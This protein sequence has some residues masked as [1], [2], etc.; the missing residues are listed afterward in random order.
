MNIYEKV[1]AIMADTPFI[2]GY[3]SRAPQPSLGG[4]LTAYY[5][6]HLDFA[7]ANSYIAEYTRHLKYHLLDKLSTPNTPSSLKPVEFPLSEEQLLHLSDAFEKDRLQGIAFCNALRQ[8][9]NY[10]DVSDEEILSS[11]GI[12]Y[13]GWLLHSFAKEQT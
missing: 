11:C 6:S 7:T 2:R 1:D 12:M 5:H 10:K 4:L 13:Q 3:I 8:V 9:E